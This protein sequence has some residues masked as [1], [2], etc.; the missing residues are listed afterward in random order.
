M[1]SPVPP[2]PSPLLDIIAIL[3]RL[4]KGTGTIKFVHLYSKTY[5]SPDFLVHRIPAKIWRNTK[6]YLSEQPYLLMTHVEG[7][8][9][10]LEHEESALCRRLDPA[11]FLMIYK[12]LSLAEECLAYQRGLSLLSVGNSLG[13]FTY[14][15]LPP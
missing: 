6:R 8:V 14:P 5:S 1:S 10:S 7:I 13:T 3:Q 15:V 2:M 4:S 9:A 11:A 12:I